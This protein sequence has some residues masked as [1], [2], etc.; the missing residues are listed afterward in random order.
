MRTVKPKDGGIKI[1]KNKTDIMALFNFYKH[2]NANQIYK[3]LIEQE[4]NI[5][6]ST[7]YRVLAFLEKNKLIIKHNFSE[8]IA[9]YELIYPNEHH[10]HLKCI[11]CNK[12]IDFVNEQIEEIQLKVARKYNFVILHHALVLFGNCE[13]CQKE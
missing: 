13:S 8:E 11:K 9:T 12:V 10:D 4:K 5:S 2:L 1:T 6:L 3:L 7:I